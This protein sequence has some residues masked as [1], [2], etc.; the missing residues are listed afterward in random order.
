MKAT[1]QLYN[2]GSGCNNKK[3]TFATCSLCRVKRL[4]Q[5]FSNFFYYGTLINAEFACGTLTL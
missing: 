4:D 3:N 2:H 1:I 5:C